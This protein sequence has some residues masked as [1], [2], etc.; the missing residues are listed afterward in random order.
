MNGKARHFLVVVVA[1]AA[2][3]T[4]ARLARSEEEWLKA[5]NEGTRHYQMRD[6]PQALL[7]WERSQKLNPAQPGTYANMAKVE[8]ILGRYQEAIVAFDKCLERRPPAKW[9]ASIWYDKATCYRELKLNHKCVEARRKSLEIEPDNARYWTRLGDALSRIGHTEEAVRAYEKSLEL[10]PG[11]PDTLDALE[12]E[13]ER[14]EKEPRP[15]PATLEAVRLSRMHS[16]VLDLKAAAEALAE[17]DKNAPPV[18]AELEEIEARRQYL[19]ALGAAIAPGTLVVV[20]EGEEPAK[21]V[22]GSAKGLEVE[23]RAGPSRGRLSRAGR[24]RS[25]P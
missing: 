24:R 9:A 25:S 19:D 18:K 13:K 11:A 7:A 23:G 5:F 4:S 21:L 10:K 2:F 6:F 3:A 22:R 16:H 12:D 1:A 14:L 8:S 17:C 20:E 15:F